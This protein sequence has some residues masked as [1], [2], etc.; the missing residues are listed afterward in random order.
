MPIKI[1]VCCCITGCLPPLTSDTV[2][3]CYRTYVNYLYS[4]YKLKLTCNMFTSSIQHTHTHTYIHMHTHICTYAHTHAHMHTCTHIFTYARTHTCMHTH[5]HA[6]THT[7]TH[8][9]TRTHLHTP[10]IHACNYVPAGYWIGPGK[11]TACW[12]NEMCTYTKYTLYLLHIGVYKWDY[13]PSDVYA[14]MEYIL[15]NNFT[16]NRFRDT[17]HAILPSTMD[18]MSRQWRLLVVT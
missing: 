13:C 8:V 7:H 2:Q 11:L 1:A 3:E 15:N 9:H 14:K 18:S 5:M 16:D 10:C 6:H 17:L 4:L 12:T